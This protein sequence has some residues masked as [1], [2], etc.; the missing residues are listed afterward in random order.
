MV[1]SVVG[2]TTD[3]ILDETENVDGISFD[4]SHYQMPSAYLVLEDYEIFSA[5]KFEGSMGKTFRFTACNVSVEDGYILA[6]EVSNSD[7]PIDTGLWLTGYKIYLPDEMLSGV[8]NGDNVDIIG[9]FSDDDVHEDENGG[10]YY[11]IVSPAVIAE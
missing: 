9:M 4:Y 8:K 1:I 7:G 2:K 10:Y 3:E 6:S 11:I 5:D